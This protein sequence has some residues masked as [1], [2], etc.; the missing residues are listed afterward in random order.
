MRKYGFSISLLVDCFNFRSIIQTWRC[1]DTKEKVRQIA[2]IWFSVMDFKFP[3]S[4]P[5]LFTSPEVE[6]SENDESRVKFQ[7]LPLELHVK[8]LSLIDLTDVLAYS[9]TC[10]IFYRNS[11]SQQLW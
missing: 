11:N 1:F 3:T 7:D 6:E 4:M 5:M 10:K 9:T 8:I 2:K